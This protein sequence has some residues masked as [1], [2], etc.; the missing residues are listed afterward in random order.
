MFLSEELPIRLAHRVQDLAHLPDGLNEMPS[1]RRVQDWYAQSFEDLT[2][3]SRPSLSTD[4]RERLMKG[5]KTNG[6][7]ANALSQATKN[8]SVKPGQYRSSPEVNGNGAQKGMATRRYYMPSEDGEDWPP[9]LNAYNKRFADALEKIK[10]RHDS[11]VTT[12]GR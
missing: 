1:I 5:M 12:V 2:T 8:P 3:L 9:D 11:V 10:R 4:V 6:K 7:D